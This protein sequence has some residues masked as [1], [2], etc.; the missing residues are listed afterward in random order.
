MEPDQDVG[1]SPTVPTV[2]GAGRLVPG[3]RVGRYEIGE[4]LGAGGM[5]EGHRAHDAELGR[6]LAIKVVRS[7]AAGADAQARLLREAQAMAKLR[8]P[9]VV[10]VFDVGT[11][12]DDVFVVMPYLEGGTLRSWL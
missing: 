9:A 8:H 5:G 4:R 10:P 3:A 6:S 2:P 12:G 7:R 11:V 1:L